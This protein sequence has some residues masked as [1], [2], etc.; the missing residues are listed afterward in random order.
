VCGG[1]SSVGVGYGGPDACAC[2]EEERVLAGKLNW[3]GGEEGMGSGRGDRRGV[4]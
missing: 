4:E 3:W 1:R 2:C